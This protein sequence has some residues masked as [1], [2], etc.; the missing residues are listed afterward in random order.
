MKTANIHR[1]YSWSEFRYT[2]Y[3]KKTEL[4]RSSRFILTEGTVCSF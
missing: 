3:P 1:Q 4:L 2:P